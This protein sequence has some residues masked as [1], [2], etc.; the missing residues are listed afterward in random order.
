MA[1]G[2]TLIFFNYRSDRARQIVWTIAEIDDQ[3][4]G[5]CP[6][7]KDNQVTI[8]KDISITTMSK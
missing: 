7:I 3:K 5:L 8:P 2:D 4:V 1:D 6:L